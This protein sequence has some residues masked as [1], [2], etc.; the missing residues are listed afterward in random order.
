VYIGAADVVKH[1]WTLRFLRTVGSRLEELQSCCVSVHFM[2]RVVNRDVGNGRPNGQM[3]DERAHVKR[4]DLNTQYGGSVYDEWMKGSP[5]ETSLCG[6]VNG[7]SCPA[8]TIFQRSGWGS[9]GVVHINDATG[10]T[11]GRML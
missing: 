6:I 11:K 7:P 4:W 8:Y 1:R 3:G 5:Q 2:R 10:D 9:G